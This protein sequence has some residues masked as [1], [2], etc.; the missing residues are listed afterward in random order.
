ME[1]AYL[2]EELEI[3]TAMHVPDD[4]QHGLISIQPSDMIFYVLI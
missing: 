3:N 2:W 4:I 1:I